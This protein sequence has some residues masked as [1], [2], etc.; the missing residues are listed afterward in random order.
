MTLDVESTMAL[1]E[2][3]PAVATFL[4]EHGGRVDHSDVAVE[5]GIRWVSLHPRAEPQE[6]FVARLA[7]SIYPHRPPSIAFCDGVGGPTNVMGAWPR[8]PGYRAPNDICMPFTAEGFALH[9]DW[10]NGPNGWRPSPN[11]YLRVV[12]QLQDDLDCRCTGRCK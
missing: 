7:W 12:T 5:D 4:E 11:P 8:I 9:P 2:D 10:A 1:A 3:E 6:C